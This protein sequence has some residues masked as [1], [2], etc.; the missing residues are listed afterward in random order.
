MLAGGL[1]AARAARELGRGNDSR[2]WG[3]RGAQDG[4]RGWRETGRLLGVGDVSKV[5]D[6]EGLLC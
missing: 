3:D 4:R 6:V 5:L 1:G 2:A